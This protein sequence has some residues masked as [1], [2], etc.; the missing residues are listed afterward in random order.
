MYIQ[1]HGLCCV[2]LEIDLFRKLLPSDPV[3]YCEMFRTISLSDTVCFLG[4]IHYVRTE[5]GRG[6]SQCATLCISK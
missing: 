6:L 2:P 5:R 3:N 1:V 4:V